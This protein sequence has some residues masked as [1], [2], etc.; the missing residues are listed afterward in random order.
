MLCIPRVSLPSLG[1]EAC[2][3]LLGCFS[4]MIPSNGS[5]THLR[6]WEQVNHPWEIRA[7]E[8]KWAKER[9]WE[10]NPHPRPEQS[11]HSARCLP[12]LIRGPASTFAVTDLLPSPREGGTVDDSIHVLVENPV[13]RLG[14]NRCSTREATGK[15]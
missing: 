4:D 7:K 10:H 8:K 2:L 12:G 9:K 3:F 1:S 6:P 11:S 5:V 14:Y 15:N 13:I